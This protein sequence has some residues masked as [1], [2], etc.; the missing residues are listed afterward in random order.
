MIKECDPFVKAI[1]RNS[2]IVP[3][4]PLIIAFGERK[5]NEAV[6][7]D[8]VKTEVAESVAPVERNG[9]AIAP[10]NSWAQ[11]VRWSDTGGW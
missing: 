1:E 5:G 8:L 11:C 2:L 4:H 7:L 6:G 9:S 10:G 3:V